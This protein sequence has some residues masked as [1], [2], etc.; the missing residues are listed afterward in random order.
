MAEASPIVCLLVDGALVLLPK[1]IIWLAVRLASVLLV[2]TQ[3]KL[4]DL[5]LA[6]DLLPSSGADF[7]SIGT[8]ARQKLFR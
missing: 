2:S 5:F 7:S 1:A 6:D 4:T 3:L 8:S